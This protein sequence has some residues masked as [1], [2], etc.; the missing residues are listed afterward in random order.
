MPIL[1][2]EQSAKYLFFVSEMLID[3]IP[4]VHSSP[5]LRKTLQQILSF[6]IFNNNSHDRENR[7]TINIS[8]CLLLLCSDE[9]YLDVALGQL[10]RLVSDTNNTVQRQLIV[11]IHHLSSETQAR[12]H[13]IKAQLLVSPS[14]AVRDLARR[15]F[16]TDH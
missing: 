14:Y 15:D 9:A 11:Q 12:L 4:L 8:K 5:S 10:Q 2:S 13:S 1:T 7:L 6:L 16:R 3:F